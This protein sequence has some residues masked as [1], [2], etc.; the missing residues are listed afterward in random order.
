MKVIYLLP[1][2]SFN[3]G[4]ASLKKL[5]QISIESLINQSVN[6]W[7][8]LILI[9]PN[10][11]NSVIELVEQFNSKK[12]LIHCIDAK[13]N[14]SLL[15]S[16]LTLLKNRN[17]NNLVGIFEAGTRLS[18]NATFEFLHSYIL[19]SN[20][21]DFLYSDHDSMDLNGKRSRP[22]FKP[23]LNLNLIT[24]FNYIGS[25]LVIKLR[26]AILHRP[27]NGRYSNSFAFYILLNY[28]KSKLPKSSILISSRS[29]IKL[30]PKILFHIRFPKDKALDAQKKLEELSIIKEYFEEIKSGISSIQLRNGVVRSFWPEL[31]DKN[32]LVSIIIPT[33]NGYHYLK[34]C[35]TSIIK[36]T[37][38]KN[39]EII[40]VDNLTTELKTLQYLK[41]VQV[42]F[43]FL[44]VLKYPYKFNYSAINNYAVKHSQGNYLAFLNND[45]E[46]IS[47]NWLGE[48]VSQAAR[49]EIGCVGAMLYYSDHTIQHGGVIVGMHGVADHAF[50]GLKHTP[51][52]DYLNYFSSARDVYAVT[53]AAMVVQKSKFLS[54]KGFNKTLKVEFNDLDLCL[55]IH[56]KGLYNLFLPYVHLYHHESKTRLHESP[57]S[58]LPVNPIEHNYIKRQ[59]SQYIKMRDEINFTKNIFDI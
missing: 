10:Q 25:F 44:R 14:S 9:K 33:R 34:K 58:T 21:I 47:K 24:S 59:W 52:S 46:V 45:I 51:K 16:A 49:K 38:Y 19:D 37:S 55:K 23:P 50:K 5:I 42:K 35:I 6:Y 53:A 27:P 56:A 3:K 22:L 29:P 32:S 8:L 48:M 54:V 43:G 2:A 4:D 13:N 7:E 15:H 41:E 12:I 1:I 26:I 36:L 11:L 40:V 39:Y 57:T 28:L 30:I 17:Q 20:N 31:N 18:I